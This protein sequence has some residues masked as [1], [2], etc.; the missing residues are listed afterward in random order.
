MQL[1]MD[2]T[3]PELLKRYARGPQGKVVNRPHRREVWGIAFVAQKC[4]LLLDQ[5][6]ADGNESYP[7]KIA[8]VSDGGYCVVCKAAETSP[9]MF[10]AGM[11]LT[12][13]AWEGVRVRV[14]V[15]W[16]KKG[17]LG[18]KSFRMAVR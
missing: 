5:P 10:R 6:D 13:E 14:E 11:T 1:K 2:V 3:P 7:C 15:R 12:L 17:R 8:D 4:R 16:I 18:L 9:T